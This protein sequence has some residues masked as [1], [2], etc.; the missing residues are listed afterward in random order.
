VLGTFL[1]TCWHPGHRHPDSTKE[2]CIYYKPAQSGLKRM[3]KINIIKTK[4]NPAIM[5]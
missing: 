3:K 2:N 5:V 1:V 4:S